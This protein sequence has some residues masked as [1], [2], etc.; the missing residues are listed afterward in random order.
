MI[1][2]N[3]L[4]TKGSTVFTVKQDARVADAV[5]ILNAENIGV[6]VVVD[7]KGTAVGILSERDV[8]RHMTA[9]TATILLSPV[10]KCMTANPVTCTSETTIEEVMQ[11]MTARRIRHIPVVDNGTLAGLISIGDIVK[12]K[13]AQA[14][15]EAAA[16]RDY[17]AS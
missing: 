6:V 10:T 17:I 13:I 1:V 4:S 15:E 11:L 2:A 3:I 16:L 9:D 8:I 12:R 14:E 7:D 5:E